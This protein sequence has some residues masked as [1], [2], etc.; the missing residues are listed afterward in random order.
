M[1]DVPR[2]VARIIQL[3]WEKELSWRPE[4]PHVQYEAKYKGTSIIFGEKSGWSLRDSLWINGNKIC[5]SK[6]DAL[7]IRNVIVGRM[8]KEIKQTFQEG[9]E[10]LM[11][12]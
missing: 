12:D 1:I 11:A 10:I 6:E 9:V 4:N 5:I 8:E 2:L 3:T 7:Q